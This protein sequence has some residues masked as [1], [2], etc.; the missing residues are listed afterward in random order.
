MVVRL[1]GATSFR[2]NKCS[3][4]LA[5]RM[6]SSPLIRARFSGAMDHAPLPAVHKTKVKAI[7]MYAEA[8]SPAPYPIGVLLESGPL[9]RLPCVV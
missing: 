7:R 3:E 6:S 2:D 9:V 4:L 8:L 5:Q 1:N